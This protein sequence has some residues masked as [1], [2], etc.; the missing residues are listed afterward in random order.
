MPSPNSAS[1]GSPKGVGHG[2]VSVLTR[3]RATGSPC[4]CATEKFPCA[5]WPPTRMADMR[6]HGNK[7]VAHPTALWYTLPRGSRLTVVC[8]LGMVE[9]PHN[10][11]NS[12]PHLMRIRT[13]E[14][15]SS[16]VAG[17]RVCR[18][19]AQKQNVS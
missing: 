9:R 17:V 10:D 3:P 15:T 18:E 11:A 2:A 14:A 5:G 1:G 6:V 8:H 13:D 19:N 16:D 4:G 7:R 12:V